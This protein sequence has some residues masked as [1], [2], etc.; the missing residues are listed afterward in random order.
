M[1]Y[2][3]KAVEQQKRVFINQL[4]KAGVYQSTD[5]QLYTK[6]VSELMAECRKIQEVKEKPV[7]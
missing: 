5:N 7:L 6:S 3:R 2:L 1:S 4:I